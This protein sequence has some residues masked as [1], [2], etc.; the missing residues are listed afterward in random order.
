[1]QR[2]LR[3]LRSNHPNV[4]RASCNSLPFADESFDTV[5][6]SEVIEHVPD[7]PAIM[8]EMYR[9]LKPG[10]TLVIGTPDYSTR[11]WLILEW[12]Y[13]KILPG[14]YAH[15]HITHFTQDSLRQRLIANHF[16]VL[17]CR[18]VGYCEMIFKARK[19]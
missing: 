17:D 4:I 15:E 16:A 6:N 13:G 10:G 8:T 12:L 19:Q 1:M 2:K 18:Y 9:I 7:N 3:W 5:I 14:A 11:L